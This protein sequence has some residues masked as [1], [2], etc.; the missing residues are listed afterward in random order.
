MS[1]AVERA[2]AQTNVVEHPAS[3]SVALMQMAERLATNPDADVSKLKQILDIAREAKAEEAEQAFNA[4]MTDAQA[5]MQPVRADAKNPQTK[6]KYASYEA[7]DEALRPIYTGHGFALSF[8]TGDAKDGEVLVLCYVSHRSGGKRTY[9]LPMPADGKGAKGNDV[10]TRTHATGSALTYGQRYLLGMVFNVA[11][12][13]KKD[14]DGNAASRNA[15]AIGPD[16]LKTLQTLAG[17]VGGDIAKLCS[18][19]GIE[20]LPDLPATK[21]A[22]A[23]GIMELKR[24]RGRQ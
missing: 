11:V 23:I 15:P 3:Q 5:A 6:S 14:D 12:S 8:D 2:E 7:L 19:F 21:Y 22:E 17:D 18:H 10:M 4:A 16:Q 13:G 1:Q 20:A 24:Q 9:R